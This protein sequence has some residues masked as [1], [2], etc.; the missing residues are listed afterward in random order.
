MTE[1]PKIGVGVLLIDQH[2]RVLLGQRSGAHGEGSWCPPGGHL[3]FGE[4]VEQCAA[5]EALEE[6][7]VVIH[8][9]TPIT[10]T[11]DVFVEANKHYIT[12]LLRAEILS[13]SVHLAEPDKFVEWR[14]CNW[15]QL[16]SP[17]FLPIEKLK[18]L[19]PTIDDLLNQHMK[20][21]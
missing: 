11:N 17:L 2:K 1:R 21:G 20:S 7:G 3:E 12:L 8:N 10:F 15:Q 14:W 6:A 13:G 5:R 19:F 16:P 4:T 18:Q 9:I